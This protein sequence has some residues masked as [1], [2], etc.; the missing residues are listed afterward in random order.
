MRKSQG[1]V[2]P[3]EKVKSP[4]WLLII[5]VFL[6]GGAGYLKSGF[7]VRDV[8]LLSKGHGKS[9]STIGFTYPLL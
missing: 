2:C 7:P 5:A 4:C 8:Q 9:D 3:N 6:G 1:S